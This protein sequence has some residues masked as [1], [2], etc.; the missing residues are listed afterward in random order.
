[1]RC[2]QAGAGGGRGDSQPS[3]RRGQLPASLVGGQDGGSR[4]PS[5]AVA[6]AAVVG[7]SGQTAESLGIPKAGGTA[8]GRRHPKAH[9]PR[10]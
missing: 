8:R 1:M 2:E 7:G 6:V 10:L 9:T 5:P 4:T 3:V